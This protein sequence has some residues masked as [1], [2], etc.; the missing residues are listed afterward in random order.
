MS[1]S[2]AYVNAVCDGCHVIEVVRL[3]AIAC[4][5]WDERFVASHLQRIGWIVE[6]NRHYCGE[7]RPRPNPQPSNVTFSGHRA[8]LQPKDTLVEFN[9]G[10]DY[11]NS[12]RVD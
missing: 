4:R 6:E 12:R 7:C 1:L 9:R 8:N 3:T 2:D 5:G 11:E 10:S